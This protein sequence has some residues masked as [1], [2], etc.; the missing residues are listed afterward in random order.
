MMEKLKLEP[1]YIVGFV[2]GEGTFNLVKYPK[3]RIR[4]QFLVFNTNKEI[5]ESIK[6]TLDLQSPILEV[7][8]MKDLIK[9][10]KR[11]YRLQVRSKEDIEKVIEF[12][13]KYLPKIKKADYGIFR[14]YFDLWNKGNSGRRI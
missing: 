5:L 13:D 2:D 11:M 4:P 12:F 14:K 3:N 7:V 1:H 9:R 8:R 6:N 10:R